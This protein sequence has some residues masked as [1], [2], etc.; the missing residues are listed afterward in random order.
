MVIEGISWGREKN[1]KKKSMKKQKRVKNKKKRKQEAKNRRICCQRWVPRV[2]LRKF[3][4]FDTHD[5]HISKNSMLNR[6]F[7]KV[8]YTGF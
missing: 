2:Q 7:P 5:V 3:S 4:C 6:E 8:V 1:K